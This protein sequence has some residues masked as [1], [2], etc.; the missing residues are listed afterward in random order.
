MQREPQHAGGPGDAQLKP[1]QGSGRGNDE[2][3]DHQA[4]DLRSRHHDRPRTRSTT[5]SPGR[6]RAGSISPT[7]GRTRRSSSPP[8]PEGRDSGRAAQWD[9]QSEATGRS[10]QQNQPS[11]AREVVGPDTRGRPRPEPLSAGERKA[12]EDRAIAAAVEARDQAR[13]EHTD[14]TERLRASV[15]P[16]VVAWVKG[17]S[18]STLLNELNGLPPDH[19]D[20]LPHCGDA[21]MVRTAYRRAMLKAHPDKV[22]GRREKMRAEQIFIRVTHMHDV[23][24][25]RTRARAGRQTGRRGDG[26]EGRGSG[27]RTRE[28]RGFTAPR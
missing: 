6:D 7:L 21:D 1:Q 9:H 17:K 26:R 16:E 2:Q 4:E 20:A 23:F 18:L 22:I 24:Q 19:P 27:W 5:R 15:T 3:Q 8:H 14:E 10:D 28:A 25:T 11:F 12:A 13:R